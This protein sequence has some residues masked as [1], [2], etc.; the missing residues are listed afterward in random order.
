MKTANWYFDFISPY[1]YLQ[2]AIIEKIT[3]K[4]FLSP[5]PI[6]FA[7]LLNHYGHL[8]PAEIPSKKKFVMEQALWLAKKYNIPF[9]LPPFHPFNPLPPLRLA[10][11]IG[12]NIEKVHHI[13]EFIWSKGLNIEDPKEFSS[14]GKSIGIN[15]A[16]GVVQDIGLKNKLRTQTNLAISE[17][18]FGIPT[19]V[20][21]KQLFWGLDSIDMLLGYLEDRSSFTKNIVQPAA[22]LPEGTAKR[23]K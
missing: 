20:I 7:G 10:V 9:K 17:G 21:D 15:D 3:G 2:S 18:V 8:G 5:R 13:F 16:N 1:A 22:S 14:L 12:E 19:I 11:S 4:I 6:L 23:K